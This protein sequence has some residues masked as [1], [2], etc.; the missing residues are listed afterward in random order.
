MS[1]NNITTIINEDGQETPVNVHYNEDERPVLGNIVFF[2]VYKD[3]EYREMG[4]EGQ[5]LSC[6]TLE[7]IYT[8]P[9]LYTQETLELMIEANKTKV[10][11]FMEQNEIFV[12]IETHYGQMSEI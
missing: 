8:V 2:T 1:D 5:W 3:V 11:D 9:F 4:E 6:P 10:L 12:G 7:A